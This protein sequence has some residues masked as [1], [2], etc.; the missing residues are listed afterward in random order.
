M[1]LK[2]F[3]S[4]FAGGAIVFI[5]V[6]VIF[7]F[8]RVHQL[9]DSKYSMLLSQS[10]LYY[11]SFTL[12]NY[13]IP[14]V[15][16]KQQTGFV[17]NGDIYQLEVINGHLHY[18]FPP[19]SPILSLPYVLFMNVLGIS[20][21]SQDGSYSRTGE[22][23]IQASLA[24]LLMAGLSSV[25][26]FTSRLLLPFGWS[27]LIAYGS[28]FG[29]QIWSTA[30]R[31]LWSDTWGI[32][33]LGLV[34]WMLVGVECKRYHLRPIVLA[35]LLSWLYFIRP[36]YCVPIV[37]IT[38]YILVYQRSAFA[39]YALT[40][41][42]WLSAFV[43]FSEY[44]YGQM[45]PSYYQPNRLTFETFW[46]ALAGN[47]ISPSRGLLVFV[48]MLL[49]VAYLLIRYRSKI[50]HPKL[51]VMSLS[52]AIVH[53]IIASG[54]VP[55]HGGHSYGP[56]YSTGLV[57]WFALLG[58]LSLEARLGWQNE[59]A[60]DDSAF[61]GKLEWTFGAILLICSVTLNGLGATAWRTALWNLNPVNVD[62]A[63][64][65]VWDWKHPQ[66]LAK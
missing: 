41:A 49:F 22:M 5:T 18:L 14:G 24:A 42:L 48:P 17:S 29:T 36:T 65:R 13:V 27:L 26:F 46:L 40:G 16:P 11:R 25:I 63:P 30:S 61:R 38:I 43:G 58:I 6:L 7:L 33:I 15:P 32:F 31:A 44:H 37:V 45:L 20:A 52:I 4:N 10:L 2:K 23:E 64:E 51:L 12:D 60:T 59:K 9:A 57:P 21:A 66:F 55:W 28:A 19:G 35:T 1:K 62:E 54:F 39:K 50:A 8:S 53:L 34:V 56:R 3:K 47:L